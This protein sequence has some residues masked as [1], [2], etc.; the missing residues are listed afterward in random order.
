VNAGEEVRM[1]L[2]VRN[3]GTRTQLPFVLRDR[4][5]EGLKAEDGEV[6]VLDLAAEET[7]DVSYRLLAERRG[8]YDLAACE[9]AMH[10]VLGVEEFRREVPAPGQLLVYPRVV[11][12]PHLVLAGA[13]GHAVRRRSL[14]SLPGQAPRGSRDYVAGDDLRQIHWKASAHRDRLTV[15]E[16]EHEQGGSVALLL[17][18]H[19]DS[20]AGDRSGVGL[21]TAV[22]LVASLAVRNLDTGNI[23]RL[24]S[25]GAELPWPHSTS[26]PKSRWRL[27]EALARAQAG[28]RGPWLRHMT[29][30]LGSLPRGSAVAVITP[31]WDEHL[32][33]LAAALQ[34]RE[35]RVYWFL[36]QLP[37]LDHTPPRSSE[38]DY[39]AA[40]RRLET[41]SP[42][43]HLIR[44]E[45]DLEELAGRWR[46]GSV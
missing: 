40:V 30:E 10:D 12:L 18:L 8:V 5:P 9:I 2:Q 17:D 20:Y 7:R 39:R 45:V 22:T 6:L 32:D 38:A 36:I 19:H 43:V 4:L 13:T 16:R 14:L 35:L 27:L 37:L 34:R 26:D 1:T 42:H 24:L 25:H 21:D 31:R 23:V 15:V 29:A 28:V 33:H 44:D 11:A 46:S 41:F 3:P